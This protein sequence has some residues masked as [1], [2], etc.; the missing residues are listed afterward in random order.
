LAFALGLV[1]LISLLVLSGVAFLLV[2]AYLFFSSL[3]GEPI[4]ALLVSAL[5]FLLAGV[6]TWSLI[7]MIR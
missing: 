6:V 2:A 4:G 5:V 7:R 1:L 3:W